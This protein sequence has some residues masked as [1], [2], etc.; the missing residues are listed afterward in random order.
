MEQL[1]PKLQ[2]KSATALYTRKEK[3]V[4]VIAT[5]SEFIRLRAM[6]RVGEGSAGGKLTLTANDLQA[7]VREKD[8][9]LTELKISS[10]GAELTRS[11]FLQDEQ[12]AHLE[13]LF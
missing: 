8:E 7:H 1:D 12:S 11:A 3:P 10:D 4:S 13:D 9:S 6:R 2:L 5:L